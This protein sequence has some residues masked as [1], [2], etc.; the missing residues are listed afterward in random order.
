[1]AITL[2]IATFAVTGCAK[3]P[4]LLTVGSAATTERVLLG[5]IIAQHLERRLGTAINR[6]PDLGS[7]P[8]AYEALLLTN[9]DVV[10]D[11]TDSICAMVLKETLDPDPSTVF[12]RVRG[13]MMRLA[14]IQVLNPL[15]IDR[16]FT[17]A[18]R[19]QEAR[20]RKLTNLSDAAAYRPGWK[21]GTTPEFRERADAYSALMS[22]YPLQL[23]SPPQSLTADK[24]YPALAE[25]R[26]DI[27]GTNDTDG[28]LN[29]PEV[30]ALQ[31]DKHA[32]R[33]TRT[34]VLVRQQALDEDS[35]LRPALDELA[36]K[37]STDV[38]R[39]LDYEVD[40]KGRKPKEV[41][42]QALNDI[43]NHSR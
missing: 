9:V 21:L 18:V 43:L 3:K 29:T 26:I 8:I 41:A 28:R 31:D 36:G 32:F 20:D 17:V 11:D 15:G 4:R 34:C 42:A 19:A 23:Q 24:L 16:R 14:R 6:R 7:T 27:A 25:S 5:E 2:A 38:M 33:Q 39:R 30:V 40:V 1:M 12:E 37:F 13:E 10:P 35:K 22:A